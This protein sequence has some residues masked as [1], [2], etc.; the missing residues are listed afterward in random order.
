MRKSIAWLAPLILSLGACAA[1]APADPGGATSV[2]TIAAKVVSE[3]IF[4]PASDDPSIRLHVR[5]KRLAG[6]SSFGQDRI[7]LFVHGAT[8]S[9]ESAFDLDLPGGSWLDIAANRGFDAYMM[10]VRGYGRSTRPASMEQAPDRNPPF[11]DTADAV[12]DV[13]AV[14]DF[15]RKRRGVSSIN[16]VGWS[17]GTTIMAGYTAKNNDAVNKLVL[18]APLWLIREAPP[19]SG[20]GAYRTVV[21]ENARKRGSNGIP[22][23]RIEELSP[24]AWFEKWWSAN[25]ASDPVG[26][27]RNPPVVRAPNGVLKDLGQYWTKGKPW[28]DPKDIRVP[29]MIVVAEWDRDTPPYMSQDLF[30]L[31]TNTRDKRLVMLGEGT[32]AIVLEK[33]RMKLIESVQHFL[34]Q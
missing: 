3:T 20:A 28:Y 12:R 17:W 15:I 25:L 16:L 31:L 2:R 30:G 5:N 6:K 21:K 29:T 24:T 10:D 19:I 18:Y 13:S 8:Y 34:E 11:A 7:V 4:V 27:S 22:A 1:Y 14:V 23:D 32:H 9:S 33:N 26:A